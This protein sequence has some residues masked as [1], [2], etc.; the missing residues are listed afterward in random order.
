M[1][2]NAANTDVA[3]TN[4]VN[5]DGLK[6]ASAPLEEQSKYIYIHILYVYA[7]IYSCAF[8]RDILL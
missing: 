8:V 4:P 5:I 2:N 1:R 7:C 6:T 3:T